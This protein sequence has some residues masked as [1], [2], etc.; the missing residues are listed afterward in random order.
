MLQ[1]TDAADMNVNPSS[2]PVSENFRE[3]IAAVLVFLA[4]ALGAM[5]AHLLKAPLE[6]NPKGMDLWKTAAQYHGLQAVALYFLAGRNRCAW[7]CI[8]GGVVIFSGTL[9]ALALTSVKWLGAITPIGGVLMMA[10]W[11]WL[12]IKGRKGR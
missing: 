10:G 3:R 12:A 6:A 4:I 2:N 7:W 5:G 9:Y 1:I 11:L 8:F